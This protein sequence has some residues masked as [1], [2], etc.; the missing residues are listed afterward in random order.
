MVTSSIDLVWNLLV[1]LI[2]LGSSCLLYII[3]YRG[4]KIHNLHSGF[5]TLASAILFTFF[6]I[7]DLIIGLFPWPF[8][9]LFLIISLIIITLQIL[10]VFIR[11]KQLKKIPTESSS[12]KGISNENFSSKQE[13]L[14]KMFHLAGILVP[15]GYYWVF[16][17]INGLVI[18]SLNTTGGRAFY[19]FLWDNVEYY[20]FLLND[21]NTSGE[22]MYFTLWCVLIFAIV[23]D[24]VRIFTRPEYSIFRRLLKSVLREK[25][26]I[27][28]GPQVLLVLG[29]LTSFF[30]PTLGWY[31]YE[32]AVSATLTACIADGLV[33]VLG[34]RFGKHKIRV[35]NGEEKSIEGFAIGFISSYLC[36]M[37]IIGPFYALFAAIIF[38]LLDVFSFHIADNL[39][40][41]I[42]LALG[43]WS[44]SMI[45]NIPIGWGV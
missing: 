31:S 44:V 28:V 24:F 6:G 2:L 22:L 33:A 27:S 39:L 7:Y 11:K 16:P 42:L 1:A 37:I 34:K 4:F 35:F 8:G 3:S 36:S 29:A 19:E 38:V 40:N 30:G 5:S 12:Y 21:L 23:Y 15:I 45:F 18:K 20:P 25:E 14:R 26:V 41:P 43:V 10:F 32:I 17:L 9:P 13:F